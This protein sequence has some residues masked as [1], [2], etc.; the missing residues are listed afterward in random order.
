MSQLIKSLQITNF[1]DWKGPFGDFVYTPNQFQQLVLLAC[2]TG[3]TPMI[4]V[5]NYILDNENDDTNIKLL[6]SCQTQ[7]DILLKDR[8]NEFSAYWN[9]QVI[10]F[11]SR[12]NE[13]SVAADKGSICYQDQLKFVRIDQSI[14]MSE[15]IEAN[16]KVLICG[17]WSFTKDM[18]K[19]LF[20]LGYTSDQIFK[21]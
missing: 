14:L 11:L 21:F 2:G 20:Q 18:I 17:T 8:L 13:E 7:H 10:Y 5:I 6:Y 19:Y 3:I 12:S 4:Q 1:V 16:V 9:F 15:I